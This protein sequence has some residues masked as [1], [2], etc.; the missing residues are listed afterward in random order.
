MLFSTSDRSLEKQSRSTEALRLLKRLTDNRQIPLGMPL[1]TV[2]CPAKDKVFKRYHRR[3]PVETYP[4][5]GNHTKSNKLY[6]LIWDSRVH[7]PSISNHQ[8]TRVPKSSQKLP[9]QYICEQKLNLDE[10]HTRIDSSSISLCRCAQFPLASKTIQTRRQ[11]AL[12]DNR[13]TIRKC[14][15]ICK[16]ISK[17]YSSSSK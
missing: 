17:S 4:C 13:A 1:T 10:T 2:V 3:I 7:T 11:C 9:T 6:R 14:I 15:I 5:L 16:L 8:T 12:S